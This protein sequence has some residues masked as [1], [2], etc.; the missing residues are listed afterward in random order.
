MNK[1]RKPIVLLAEDEPNITF[2]LSFILERAGFEVQTTSDGAQ[3]ESQARSMLPDV[4][5]LDLMLPN[6]SG[7]DVLRDI[8][9][10]KETAHIPILVL[11]AK[12]QERDLQRAK[13]N[14]A[15]QYMTK[16][17]SNAEVVKTVQELVAQHS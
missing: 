11:S 17:F 4:L 6:K 9:K 5:I 1:A 8:R 15:N 10:S 2:S 14:G 12:A 7:F 3:V 13:D 16:P